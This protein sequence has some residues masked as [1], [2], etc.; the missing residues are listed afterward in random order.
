MSLWGIE[1]NPNE[2]DKHVTFRKLKFSKYHYQRFWD[3]LKG[4]FTQPV[5]VNK[6]NLPIE[7][8]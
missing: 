8:L 2:I 1:I 3:M 6:S 5:N 7:H 4:N